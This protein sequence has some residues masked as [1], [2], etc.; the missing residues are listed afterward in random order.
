MINKKITLLTLAIGL[1][2]CSCVEPFNLNLKS[3][4]KILTVDA[5][6]TDT[7]EEQIITLTETVNSNGS[8][9]SLPVLKATASILVNGNEKVSFIEKG[10]GVY[11]L[12][13]TFKLKPN[14]TYRLSFS[15]ADGTKKS[16]V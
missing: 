2:V 4:L 1:W 12:P 3:D 11:A 10:L 14:T 16:V 7:S 8:A 5:T 9:Y 13:A 6:L 15:K